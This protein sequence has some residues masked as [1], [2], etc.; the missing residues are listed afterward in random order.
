MS[1]EFGLLKFLQELSIDGK[2]I[3]DDDKDPAVDDLTIPTE[4]EDPLE[5]TIDGDEGDEFEDDPDADPEAPIDEPPEEGDETNEPLTDDADPG[6]ASTGDESSDAP[7]TEDWS[8]TDDGGVE[9]DPMVDEPSGN[10]PSKQ[11]PIEGEPLDNTETEPSTEEPGDESEDPTNDG[12]PDTPET[13]ERT[14]PDIGIETDQF[15]DEPTAADAPATEPGEDEEETPPA[16]DPALDDVTIDQDDDDDDL[17][18]EGD[19][20]EGGED[21]PEGGEVDD[22]TNETDDEGNAEMDPTASSEDAGDPTTDGNTDLGNGNSD[23]PAEGLGGSTED[24]NSLKG[25][26]RDLFKDL[27]PEQLSIKN[28]ELMKNYIDLYDTVNGIFDSINHIPK[29]FENTR[30][31]E[32]VSQ[33]FLELKEQVNMV[34]TTSYATKTYAENYANFQEFLITIE[35]LNKILKSLIRPSDSKE[36]K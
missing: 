36:D 34:I 13:D 11:P 15:A 16:E 4:D 17:D 23:D 25:L 30:I 20:P 14:G 26:E 5:V 19:T 18:E 9:D 22:L 2:E 24:P 12:E 33:A 29:T 31:L 6:N 8:E 1:D 7:P 32:F 35:K 21:A 10:S 27:T 3:E 28:S